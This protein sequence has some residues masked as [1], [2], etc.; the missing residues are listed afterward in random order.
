MKKIHYSEFLPRTLFSDH[1]HTL[2]KF[3]SHFSPKIL[4]DVYHFFIADIILDN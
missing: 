3:Y 2:K 4:K 1:Y